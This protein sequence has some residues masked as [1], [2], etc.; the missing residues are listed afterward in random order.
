MLDKYEIYMK[1]FTGKTNENNGWLIFI[2]LIMLILGVCA[3]SYVFMVNIVTMYFIGGFI[4]AGG[5]LQLIGVAKAYDGF[6]AFFWSLIS[7]AYI[8]IGALTVA[9]PLITSFVL[10]NFIAIAFIGV[11]VIKLLVS[12]QI[13]PFDGWHWGFFAGVIAILT[14]VLIFTTPGSFTWVIGLFVAL[15]II[16]QGAILTT[17]GFAIRSLKKGEK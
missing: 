9:N 7:L 16:F 12:L 14:G 4:I 2:G 5:I 1:K 15:D 10:T 3:L 8:A 6:K 11:G 17:I 13:R